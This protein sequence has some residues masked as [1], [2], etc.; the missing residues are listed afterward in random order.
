MLINALFQKI[1]VLYPKDIC[2]ILNVFALL[3]NI[4]YIKNIICC[5]ETNICCIQNI[6]A[7]FGLVL[8]VVDV[9]FDVLFVVFLP[10]CGSVHGLFLFFIQLLANVSWPCTTWSLG[11][12]LTLIEGKRW[13]ISVTTDGFCD[14][15]EVDGPGNGISRRAEICSR[16]D[17]GISPI[18]SLS[19]LLPIG[20]GI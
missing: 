14:P 5:I 4:W 17:T 10:R 12:T 15:C 8:G 19:F 13:D 1:Y 18:S 2:Y 9:L 16:A 20:I 7:V 3:K 6:Y 11:S